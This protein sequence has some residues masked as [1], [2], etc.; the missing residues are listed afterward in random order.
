MNQRHD[1]ELQLEKVVAQRKLQEAL[2]EAQVQSEKMRHES[3]NQ[4]IRERDAI[5]EEKLA[6][7]KTLYNRLLQEQARRL[8]AEQALQ[9]N[10]SSTFTEHIDMAELKGR[11]ARVEYEHRELKQLIIDLRT[12]LS[13][14]FT[15]QPK[16]KS[17]V[18]IPNFIVRP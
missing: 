12:D 10:E 2:E 13:S 4:I 16:Y 9:N 17:T 3:I 14:I 18:N 11:L 8:R 1:E 7:Q 5:C 6:A 15:Q